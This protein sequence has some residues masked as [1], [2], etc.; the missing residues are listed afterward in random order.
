MAGRSTGAG[1]KGRCLGRA[2]AVDRWWSGCL[3]AAL[4]SLRMAGLRVDFGLLLEPLGFVKVLEWVSKAGVA[5]GETWIFSYV[6][7]G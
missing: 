1:L 7:A 5:Q 4:L 6:L 2:T 3:L